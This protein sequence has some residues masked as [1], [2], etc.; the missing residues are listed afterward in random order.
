MKR[1]PLISFLG[2]SL[3]LSI[4]AS[5]LSAQENSNK[6]GESEAIKKIQNAGGRVQRISAADESIEISFALSD[7]PVGD[8]QIASVRSFKNVI[9]LNLAGTKVTGEGLKHIAKLPLQKL[10]L[11]K[12]S[13]GDDGLKHL[14]E[15]KDLVYLN[16]YDTQVTDAGLKHLKGLKNLR[17]LYVWKSKVTATGMKQLNQALPQLTIVGELKLKPVKKEEPKKADNKKKDDAKK[18]PKQDKPKKKPD[19]KK[20][21]KPAGKKTGNKKEANDKKDSTKKNDEKD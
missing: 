15:L 18:S 2:L 1:T 10:H 7:K 16:L 3:I 20:E 19:Q 4:N 13:I 21:K 5:F 8:D 9:W 12:T 17:N 6:K 11:E 14:K